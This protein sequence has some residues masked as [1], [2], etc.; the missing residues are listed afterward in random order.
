MGSRDL[1]IACQGIYIL[2]VAN[3]SSRIREYPDMKAE[4]F[5]YQQI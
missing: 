5:D 4:G 3:F 1:Q 2:V